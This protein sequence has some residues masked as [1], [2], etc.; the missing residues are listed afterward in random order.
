[1]NLRVIN[2]Y[3]V[4]CLML[5]VPARPHSC[6]TEN[7]SISGC[8]VQRAYS[9]DARLCL[10][11]T[12]NP[13]PIDLWLH[14]SQDDPPNLL[15]VRIQEVGLAA[16]KNQV[17]DFNI[18]NE[19]RHQWWHRIRIQ[20]RSLLGRGVEGMNY[21]LYVGRVEIASGSV[22]FARAKFMLWVDGTVFLS[23]ICVLGLEEG[24][25]WVSKTFAD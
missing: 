19:V 9:G 15:V 24:N 10:V 18:V 12:G 25:G 7:R 13:F 17:L 16:K 1:M 20:S 21:K 5:C 4:V 23:N 2:A 14:P 11:P 3:L 6:S 22:D 8:I